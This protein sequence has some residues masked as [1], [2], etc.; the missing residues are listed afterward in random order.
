MLDIMLHMCQALGA[1][2]KW[3]MDT[4]LWFAIY[5]ENAG[6]YVTHVPSIERIYEMV[7]GCTFMVYNIINNL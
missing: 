6:Y 7:G 2:M 5:L 1:F 3:L 4:L